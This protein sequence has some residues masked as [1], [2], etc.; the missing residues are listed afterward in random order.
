MMRD[1]TKE[2]YET[3]IEFLVNHDW[4]DKVKVSA[5]GMSGVNI[6][7]QDVDDDDIVEL[8]NSNEL[9]CHLKP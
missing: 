5:D 8:L 7:I 2:Q 9:P 6:H 4:I 3:L 1:I